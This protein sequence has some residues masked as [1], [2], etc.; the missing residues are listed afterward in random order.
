MIYDKRYRN[1][2]YDRDTKFAMGLACMIYTMFII[3]LIHLY[4]DKIHSLYI[5][6]RWIKAQPII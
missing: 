2:V 6:N 1:I 3:V 5:I 4:M